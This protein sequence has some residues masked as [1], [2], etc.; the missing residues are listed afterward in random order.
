MSEY[1]IKYAKSLKISDVHVLNS[2]WYESSSGNQNEF[3]TEDIICVQHGKYYRRIMRFM[4]GFH[5][6]GGNRREETLESKEIS[7]EEFDR[8]KTRSGK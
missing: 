8:L 5:Y 4:H 3:T 7:R 2:H 1:S 6:A